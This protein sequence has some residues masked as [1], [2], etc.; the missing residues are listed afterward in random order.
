[1]DEEYEEMQIGLTP[2]ENG[3]MGRECSSY[4][5]YFKV[6]FG[7][8]LPI[9]YQMCPYCGYK[10]D[11]DNFFTQDQIEYAGDILANEFIAPALEDFIKSLE[12]FKLNNTPIEFDIKQYQEKILETNVICDN[13][14]LDFSIYGVFSNCPDCGQL[15][16]KVIFDKSIESSIKK[17]ELYKH[18]SLDPSIRNDLPKDA[19]RAY[20]KSQ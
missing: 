2:D 6:K 18:E 13:C 16:A 4:E 19:L 1:M 17:L 9:T 15:N 12:H 20:P 11:S 3:R 7:T 8:G 14:G 10:D 5:K